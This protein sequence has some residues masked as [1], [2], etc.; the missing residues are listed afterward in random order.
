MTVK[1][2]M[3]EVSYVSLHGNSCFCSFYLGLLITA[4]ID[5]S[6]QMLKIQVSL[7]LMIYVKLITLSNLSDISSIAGSWYA[8]HNVLCVSSFKS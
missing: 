2:R 5:Y 1:Q 4:T 8:P 3:D 7:M 6:L